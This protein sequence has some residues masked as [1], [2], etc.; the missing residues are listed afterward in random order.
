M[1]D[2]QFVRE[3]AIFAQLVRHDYSVEDLVSAFPGSSV[4]EVVQ[5]LRDNSLRYR[6]T[7]E[8]FGYLGTRECS[9]RYFNV[10]SGRFRRA[11]S[12]PPVGSGEQGN[13]HCYG[14]STT[15]GHNVGDEETFP[16]Y[17]EELLRRSDDSI[18]VLNF[19]AGNHTSLHASLHLLDHCLA[20]RTPRTAIMFNGVNDLLYA[21]SGADGIIP[22]LDQALLLSQHVPGREVPIGEI[23][24]LVPRSGDERLRSTASSASGHP[25]DPLA[26]VRA[27]YAVAAAIHD[28]CS[29]FWGVR[30]LRV[31]EPTPFLNCRSDQDLVPRL[32]QSSSGYETARQ[33]AQIVKSAGGPQALGVEEIQDLTECGQSKLDGPL[34]VDEIHASPLLNRHIAEV[35]V[36]SLSV[37]RSRRT[38]R[39]GRIRRRRKLEGSVATRSSREVT[40][41]ESDLYPLW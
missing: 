22:F 5:R 13:I 26:L 12:A 24:S 27:R 21:A 15:S 35:L 36:R 4:E 28:H 9:S 41:P 14:G 1:M 3:N 10:A 16:H 20:G 30:V 2:R 40:S 23:A 33:L 29:Q 34:F 25:E 31:W 6:R 19:G 8:R 37:Q 32:R 7:V 38:S 39:W 18:R 11:P 17:L